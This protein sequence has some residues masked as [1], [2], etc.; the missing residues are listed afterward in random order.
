MKA[1]DGV[2]NKNNGCF[3][4]EINQRGGRI[5]RIAER[6]AEQEMDIVKLAEKLFEDTSVYLNEWV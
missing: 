6:L 3:Q 2:I 4:I 1:S 5:K